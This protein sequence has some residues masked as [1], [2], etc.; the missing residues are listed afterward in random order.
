MPHWSKSG[1]LSMLKVA[2]IKEALQTLVYQHGE[3]DDPLVFV[4]RTSVLGKLRIEFAGLKQHALSATNRECQYPKGHTFII[5]GS[6]GAGKTSIANKVANDLAADDKIKVLVCKSVPEDGEIDN[7]RLKIASHI[8]GFSLDTLR[9][10]TAVE[11]TVEAEVHIPLVKAGGG[12]SRSGTLAPMTISSMRDVR[13]LAEDRDMTPVVVVIDEVQ[14]IV[15]DSRVASFVMDLHTQ[16]EVPVLLVCCG[17]SNSRKRLEDIGLTRPMDDHCLDIG[18]LSADETFEAARK[19]LAIIR[20]AGARGS[21]E[22]LDVL[23]KKI[24]ESSDHW[25]RHLTCYLQGILQTLLEQDTPSFDALDQSAALEKGHE[26]RQSYYENRLERSE[27][28][29]PIIQQI[30]E[31]I[32]SG[33]SEKQCGGALMNMIRAFEGDEKEEMETTFTS[34]SIALDKLVGSGLVSIGKNRACV[35][36]IPSMRA[37]IRDKA[38][39]ASDGLSYAGA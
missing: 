24:A 17:L 38:R 32:E 28:P 22:V 37:F 16:D 29:A 7:L 8:T 31:R 27:L 5:Q 13:T 2:A 12:V 4:G 6:P 9:R 23:S 10:T 30:Y 25:P 11:G 14:N 18:T 39:E 21:D 19:S 36:P 34:T 33:L 1:S 15:K 26:L 3:R 20:D 35:I